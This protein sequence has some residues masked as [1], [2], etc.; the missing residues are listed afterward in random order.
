MAARLN[1]I[2]IAQARENRLDARVLVQ[3]QSG[4]QQRSAA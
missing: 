2:E 4:N 1:E 3:R